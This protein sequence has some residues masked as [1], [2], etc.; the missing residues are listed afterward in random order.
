MSP[1]GCC[2]YEPPPPPARTSTSRIAQ[3][4]SASA[5]AVVKTA[6]AS[7]TL[8]APPRPTD[9][10]IPKATVSFDYKDILKPRRR[11]KEKDPVVRKA[12][13]D[14]LFESMCE[15]IEEI[16]DLLSQS[17]VL[18]HSPGSTTK[19]RRKACGR[20]V[21]PAGKTCD[22]IPFASSA[23]GGTGAITKC[24]IALGNSIQGGFLNWLRKSAGIRDGDHYLLQLT[25]V[26]CQDFLK[27]S[28]RRNLY[29]RQ[30][31]PPTSG[32]TSQMQQLDVTM[33]GPLGAKDIFDH[34]L[35]YIGDLSSGRYAVNISLINGGVAGYYI[36]DYQGATYAAAYLNATVPPGATFDFTLPEDAT[37]VTLMLDSTGDFDVSGSMTK[38]SEASG[39]HQR[40]SAQ[41]WLTFFISFLGVI[42]GT[43]A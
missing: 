9:G 38:L 6:T 20:V 14:S 36:I 39:A 24:I 41:I 19:R 13:V 15:A 40:A 30:Q 29:R 8:A 21:C 4:A 23:E 28:A 35:Y 25:N 27:G 32:L 43:L 2:I 42:S 5:T 33:F 22:E 3:T 11:S 37:G 26:N 31:S 16:G 10:R 18:T 1:T 12:A 17:L 34:G 7:F